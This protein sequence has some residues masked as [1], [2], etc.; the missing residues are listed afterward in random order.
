V[1]LSDEDECKSG[2]EVGG[3]TISVPGVF[4]SLVCGCSRLPTGVADRTECGDGVKQIKFVALK[5][6]ADPA[7]VE[8]S[9]LGVRRR[10]ESR[11]LTQ[12]G[13]FLVWHPG[14]D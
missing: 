3:R 6:D 1:R 10:S 7:R 9:S 5:F 12:A 11:R 8:V 4:P 14:R 13:R 2:W